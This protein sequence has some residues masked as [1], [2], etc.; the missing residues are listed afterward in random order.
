MRGAQAYRLT[1]DAYAVH[2]GDKAWISEMYGYAFGAANNNVWHK[3]DGF[4]MLYPGYEPRGASGAGERRTQARSPASVSL[5]PHPRPGGGSPPT[6]PLTLA[7]VC[8]APML[9]VLTRTRTR[10]TEESP[11]PSHQQATPQSDVL[12]PFPLAN[13]CP[14]GPPL[15]PTPQT[16]SPS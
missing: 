13:P 7:P 16:A 3:W 15:P 14:A 10:L 1:G 4:S 5:S 2:P 9:C 6:H 11:P 8:T 12:P